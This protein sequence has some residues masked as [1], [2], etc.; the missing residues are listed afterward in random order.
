MGSA[1]IQAK[2]KKGLAKAIAKTGSASSEKVFLIKMVNT[3]GND[4]VFNPPNITESLV[5]LVNAIFKEYNQSLI[6]GNIVAGDRQL[7][8]DNTVIIEVGDTIEQGSTRYTVIDL[9]QSAPTSDVLVYMP[10]V[11][12]K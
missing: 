8:T 1:N 7:V 5:E 9:G 3:G 2:I 10:Q 12:V 4:P 6:G 11:R